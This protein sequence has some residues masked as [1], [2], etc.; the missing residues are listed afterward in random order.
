ME[1]KKVLNTIINADC[2]ETM[3]KLE[4]GSVDMIFADPPYN[5][6]LGETLL[7]PDNS[8]V[9]GVTEEWDSF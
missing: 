6:Q 9:N 2:V 4:E 7:R 8:V 5:M 3:N 1:V